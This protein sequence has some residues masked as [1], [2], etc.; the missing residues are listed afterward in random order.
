MMTL[1]LGFIVCSIDVFDEVWEVIG[2]FIL[3]TEEFE[4]T[5]QGTPFTTAV[6]VRVVV[7]LLQDDQVFFGDCVSL[8]DLV[9][10][11]LCIRGKQTSASRHCI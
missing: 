6:G 2:S 1:R 8:G 7:E 11:L 10:L 9:A 3:L 5:E 4:V